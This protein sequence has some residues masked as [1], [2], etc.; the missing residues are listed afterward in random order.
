MDTPTTSTYGPSIADTD[1]DPK[2][3]SQRFA[4]S[5][6]VHPELTLNDAPWPG[7]IFIIS[8]QDTSQVL[9]YDKEKGIVLKEYDGSQAQRWICHS[10]SGWLGFAADPGE[11]TAFIGH[12][13]W[14]LRCRVPH[15]QWNEM[16]CVRKRLK[17]LD[18]F[19]I[20]MRGNEDSLWPVGIYDDGDVA[21]MSGS[22]AWWGFTM[23]A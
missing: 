14:K 11:N 5:V 1:I 10:K 17:G 16:F 7:H 6:T 20:L 22:E 4:S 18:G 23:I 2:Y 13:D 8:H 19:Q 21:I 15:L 9:T 12:Y 3:L